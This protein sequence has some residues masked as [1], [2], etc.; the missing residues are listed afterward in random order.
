M[1]ITQWQEES[2]LQGQDPDPSLNVDSQ[3]KAVTPN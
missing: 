1:K 2:V 3:Q